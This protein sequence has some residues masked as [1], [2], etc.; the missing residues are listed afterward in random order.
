MIKN[1]FSGFLT[2]SDKLGCTVTEDVMARDYK[3][4]IQEEEG[5]YN[6]CSQNKGAVQLLCS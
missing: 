3:F 4:W 2:K 1:L 6:I 5:L